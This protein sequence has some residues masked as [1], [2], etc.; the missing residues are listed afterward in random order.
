M[1]A[2][3]KALR[4]VRHASKANKG[5]KMV[6]SDLPKAFVESPWNNWT[7]NATTVSAT[8]TSLV[9]TVTIDTLLSQIATLLNL[10]SISKVRIKVHSAQV[11]VTPGTTLLFPRADFQFYEL[12][13]SDDQ[14]RNTQRDQGNWSKP[15]KAGYCFPLVDQSEVFS[16][17]DNARKV[18]SVT[19]GIADSVVVIRVQLLWRSLPE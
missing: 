5:F 11:W 14:L 2:G 19:T 10:T 17:D 18:L 8:S 9:T 15:A 3:E 13:K 4:E 12:C 7:Y 6:P 1:S 16:I